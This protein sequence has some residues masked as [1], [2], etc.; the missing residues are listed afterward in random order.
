MTSRYAT[1]VYSENDKLSVLNSK[2]I[3][4]FANATAG[5]IGCKG[6]E[7]MRIEGCSFINVTSSKNAGAVYADV[8]KNEHHP[9]WTVTISNSL[10]ENCSSTFGGAYIQLG[11]TLNLIKSNFTN[12][13]AEYMGGAIYLSN[14]TALIATSKFDKST[15][16]YHYGGALYIDDSDVIINKCDFTNSKSRTYGDAIYMNDCRYDIKNSQFSFRN[17]S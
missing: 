11:G 7:S 10:F 12:N 4:L 16:K 5:A 9:K 15:A 1:A 13:T 6:T 8:N 2:F 17:S 14:T 3:N